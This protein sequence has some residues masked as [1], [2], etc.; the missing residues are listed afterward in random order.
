MPTG[1]PG[2]IARQF[3]TQ[4]THYV[5]RRIVGTAGNA[6]YT[7]GTLPAGANI[8]RISTLV[9]T[10]FSGGTPT[11]AFGTA[12]SNAAF[13]AANGTPATTAGRNNVTLIATGALGLSADTVL[14]A[15]VAG[16]PTAGV[17]DVEVEFTVEN[18]G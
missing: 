11:I 5:R 15:T 13:F 18:D 16:N 17:L 8:L 14:T 2:T 10:A 4:Q 9:R 3:H 1:T 12:A 7:L 6:T